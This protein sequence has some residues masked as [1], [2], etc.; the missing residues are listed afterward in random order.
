MKTKRNSQSG[1]SLIELMFAAGVVAMALSIIFGSLVSMSIMGRLNVGRTEATAMVASVLEEIN[2][3]PF[4]DVVEYVPPDLK[5]PGKAFELSIEA[6]IPAQSDGEAEEE[7]TGAS[8]GTR[9]PVPLPD[10][11]DS[12]TLPD[13]VEIAVTVTWQDDRGHIYR[14]LSS[15]LKER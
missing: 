11:F 13:P 4:S 14:S 9:V 8:D 12:S 2:T 5:G 10:D 15:T 6:I 3:L 1:M 7:E